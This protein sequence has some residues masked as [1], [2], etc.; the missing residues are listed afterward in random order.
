MLGSGDAKYVRYLIDSLD[1]DNDEIE[2]H[3]YV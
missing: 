1:I 3:R 2:S